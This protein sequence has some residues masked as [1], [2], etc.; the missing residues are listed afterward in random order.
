MC[1]SAP[2]LAHQVQLGLDQG[3]DFDS[4]VFGTEFR[5][6][7]D[8][9]FRFTPVLAVEQPE[10]R[11]SYSLRYR[12]TYSGYFDTQ[13]I[14]GWDQALV[15]R[16]EYKATGR[17][18]FKLR[19][20]FVS[21]RGIRTNSFVDDSGQT[22]VLP[23]QPGNTQRIN[24][25]LAYE[26][27][28]SSRTNGRLG[29]RYDYWDYTI[30]D[31]V[32]NQSLGGDLQLLHAPID[33]LRVGF[34]VD[35]RYRAFEASSSSP[36]SYTT[37]LNVNGV[38]EYHFSDQLVL[39][40]SGG[41]A[42]VFSEQSEPDPALVSRWSP[43]FFDPVACPVGPCARV[44]GGI[45]APTV[46]SNCGTTLGFPVLDRCGLT[47]VPIAA[48]PGFPEELVVVPV[49]PN[50]T[51]FG[52]SS[53]TLT[54]FVNVTLTRRFRRG[55]VSLSFVRNEDGASGIGRSS[56]VNSGSAVVSWALSDL[57]QLNLS[58]SYFLRESV[59]RFPTTEVS[60]RASS[61]TFGTFTLAE[62]G[63]V[64]A[65][66]LSRSFEQRLGAVDVGLSRQLSER[67]RLRF[68]FN[69]YNQSQGAVGRSTAG[70]FDRFV[71]GVAYVF[72]FAPHKF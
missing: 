71:L 43:V 52:R 55:S 26:R 70:S 31:R 11:L 66:P 22:Q 8:T 21:V 50:Q 10:S 69:Y 58:G 38:V 56:V 19:A 42:G 47:A 20:N 68:R 62:A 40:L 39:N 60:A 15:G 59:A 2:A 54:Y 25:D 30:P 72:Q 13:S 48:V 67:S 3:L 12:P 1:A 64:V 29:L 65:N 7:R 14:N 16:S 46:T 32:G 9:R 61:E 28:I 45:P 41:P 36:A 49:D 4:N 33:R 35:G 57:W 37:V 63:F 23:T 24:V 5:Q 17:D 51:F 18:T 27:A 53:E 44:W 6:T 34:N